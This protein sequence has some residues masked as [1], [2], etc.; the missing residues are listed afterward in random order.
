MNLRDESR[1][2]S[3]DLNLRAEAVVQAE[4]PWTREGPEAMA[5]DRA[6]GNDHGLDPRLSI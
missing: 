6:G 2:R 1:A 4:Q 3:A 5:P